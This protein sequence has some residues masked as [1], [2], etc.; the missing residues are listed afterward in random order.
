[1]VTPYAVAFSAGSFLHVAL[2][3]LLPD[4]HPAGAR[5]RDMLLAL[6]GGLVLTI[7]I[8]LLARD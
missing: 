5:R 8:T 4:L 2:T 1:M 6:I 7:G 3:D